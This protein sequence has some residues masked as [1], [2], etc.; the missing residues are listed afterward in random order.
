MAGP[1]AVKGDYTPSYTRQYTSTP[2]E[3]A[4]TPQFLEDVGLATEVS[5]AGER[6]DQM[7]P[8]QDRDDRVPDDYTSSSVAE[9]LNKPHNKPARQLKGKRPN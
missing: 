3:D 1:G 8:V 7:T 4:P 6:Y 2:L 5:I 9:G